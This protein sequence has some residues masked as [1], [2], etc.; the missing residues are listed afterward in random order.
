[1]CGQNVHRNKTTYVDLE[2][3]IRV[4]ML[5]PSFEPEE[6]RIS[7]FSVTWPH[8]VDNLS[9]ERMAKA[10]FL[11]KGSDD[12]AICFYCRLCLYQWANTDIPEIEHIKYGFTCAY[13]ERTFGTAFIA[14]HNNFCIPEDEFFWKR[15]SDLR[16]QKKQWIRRL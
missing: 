9:P 3:I 13:L 16:L 1:M 6:A 8:R 10:G 2:I 14:Q 4:K 15:E 5:C 7:S 11:Y 12:R